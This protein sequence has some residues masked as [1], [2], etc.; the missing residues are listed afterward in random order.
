V[1]LD[2]SQS[3]VLL[4][5]DDGIDAPGLALLERLVAPLVRELWVVAPRQEQSATSHAMTIHSPL[6]V[7]D[8]GEWRKAVTG[9]PADAALLALRHIMPEPPDLVIS[10]INRGGNLGGDVLYSGTVGAAMEAALCG[11]P[12]IAFSQNKASHSDAPWRVAEAHLTEVLQTLVSSEWPRDVIINVNFPNA[13]PDQV[14]GVKVAP[15]GRRKPG[16]S[17]QLGTDPRGDDFV[18]ISSEK[19]QGSSPPGSDEEWIEKG[20][21]TVTPLTVDMTSFETMAAVQALWPQT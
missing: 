18:W 8:M 4:T 19:E 17:L 11:V 2:L 20:W 16:G 9:M 21:I 3:R 1:A 7:V 6:R 14:R 10:G 13:E 15:Q 5:N 12:A